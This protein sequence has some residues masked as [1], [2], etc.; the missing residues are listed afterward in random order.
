[1]A[2][3]P[4]KNIQLHASSFVV[5]KSSFFNNKLA[6]NDKT[7]KVLIKPNVQLKTILKN[8]KK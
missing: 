1:M 4:A 7:F 5:Q 3:K 8:K 2:S 6:N